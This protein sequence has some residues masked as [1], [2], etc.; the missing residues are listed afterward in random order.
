MKRTSVS[1]VETQPPAPSSDTKRALLGISLVLF[2]V[3]VACLGVL[4]WERWTSHYTL[5]DETR[6]IAVARSLFFGPRLLIG[7]SYEFRVREISV[8]HT[9]VKISNNSGTVWTHDFELRSTSL[10]VETKSD[11]MWVALY[12]GDYSISSKG[13]AT[14]VDQK[15]LAQLGQLLVYG[16]MPALTIVVIFLFAHAD[17]PEQMI[18]DIKKDFLTL[19]GL[20][21][22]GGGWLILSILLVMVIS[23]L[24]EILNLVVVLLVLVVL[25]AIFEGLKKIGGKVKERLPV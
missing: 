5:E 8:V 24:H 1:N 12:P 13:A 14:E 6:T 4:L 19:G 3:D 22:L 21:L 9:I 7:V 2:L 25:G 18:P 20:A 23:I 17:K 11:S 10:T 16:L 15:E